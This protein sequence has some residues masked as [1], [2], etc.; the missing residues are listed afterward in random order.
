MTKI[1]KGIMLDIETMGTNTRAPITQIAVMS[2]DLITGDRFEGNQLFLPLQP[3]LEMV[4]PR[5]IDAD[6]IFWWMEQEPA[7]RANL[8][9]SQAGEYEQ[10]PIALRQLESFLAD[11]S[12]GHA[13]ELWARG[14]HFDVA[15][16]ESLYRETGV[17]VPWR[18]DRV[19]DLRTLM[20]VA[21]I[22]TADVVRDSTYLPH[23]AFWDCAYQIDCYKAAIE[24]LI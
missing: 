3:Q 9:Y 8:K 5:V 24:A 1:T 4:P 22:S 18:Y 6:T 19:R 16:L 14:P 20:G 13:Y 17:R 7:A 12:Q 11:L 21:N 2:F 15:L 23:D 10:V